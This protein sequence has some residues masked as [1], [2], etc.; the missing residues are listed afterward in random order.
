MKF[1]VELDADFDSPELKT[2]LIEAIATKLIHGPYRGSESIGSLKREAEAAVKKKIDGCIDDRIETIIDD[3]MTD[4]I[5]QTDGYGQAKSEKKTLHQIV[6]EKIIEKLKSPNYSAS[7]Q[8]GNLVSKALTNELQGVMKE[9]IAKLSADL[10]AEFY[11]KLA[12]AY[13]KKAGLK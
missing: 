1:N 13:R 4:G 2:Q 6:K 5:Y 7:K 8:I 9:Q 10:D 3:V 12:D 11:T